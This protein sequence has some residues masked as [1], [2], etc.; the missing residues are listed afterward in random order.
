[1]AFRVATDSIVATLSDAE[2]KA[3]E[4][5]HCNVRTPSTKDLWVRP[6][7]RAH[8]GGQL[9]NVSKQAQHAPMARGSIE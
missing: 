1:V 9:M 4:N 5:R 3:I 7:R 8:L 6:V 2:R